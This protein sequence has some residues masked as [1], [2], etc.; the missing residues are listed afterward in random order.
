VPASDAL[1]VS[2]LTFIDRGQHSR[3]EYLRLFPSLNA[4]YELRENMIL[5]AAFYRSI[6]RPDFNQYAGGITLPDTERSPSSTN[7]ITVNNAGIKAWSANT[8]RVRAEYYFEQVGQFTVSAFRR[9]Y[10][11]FFGST[12]FAAT[13]SFLAFYG[14]DPGTYDAYEVSTQYNLPSTLHTYGMDFD[15]KQVLTFLPSWARGVQV[16]ANASTTRV[17]GAET[18]NF[19]GY[20]PRS[21]SLGVSLTRERFNVRLNWNFRSRAR[22]NE[23]TGR[24]IA[25]GTF[26]WRNS[27]SLFDAQ[28]DWNLS[29]RFALFFNMRNIGDV[30]EDVERLGPLTPEVAQFRQRET[31][32]ALWTF[33]LKGSF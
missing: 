3:K 27:R 30:P 1:G 29:R 5:R 25:P 31:W 9:D 13:P 11:N 22:R 18:Q 14:L 7:R 15:Y 23:I 20:I 21:G 4:S 16:F 8:V 12:A 10:E 19:L 28:G 24:G 26:E 17:T 32:G 33:G 6:G 2:Q